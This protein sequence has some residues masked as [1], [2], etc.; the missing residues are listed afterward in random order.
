MV[1]RSV[2]LG[3]VISQI[4][5]ACLPVSSE[6]ALIGSISKPMKPR[7]HCFEFLQYII[8]YD[9]EHCGVVNLD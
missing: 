9:I 2:M 7:V 1:D 5:A 8:L 3:H 4:R 6:L